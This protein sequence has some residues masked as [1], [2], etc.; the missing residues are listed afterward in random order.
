MENE[1]PAG[2]PIEVKSISFE[3]TEFPKGQRRYVEVRVQNQARY[4]LCNL[5]AKVEVRDISGLL[6]PCAKVIF[7][8]NRGIEKFEMEPLEVTPSSIWTINSESHANRLPEFH[9]LDEAELVY[10]SSVGGSMAFGGS[11]YSEQGIDV[12]AGAEYEVSIIFV[13]EDPGGFA[14][15]ILFTKKLTA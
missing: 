10:P 11:F 5:R 1:E 9:H 7:S 15:T 8:R 14:H 13:A 12:K 4:T 2:D 3:S 6:I